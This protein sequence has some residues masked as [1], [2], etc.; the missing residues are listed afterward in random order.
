SA[1]RSRRRRP[2]SAGPGRGWQAGSWHGGRAEVTEIPD[3]WAALVLTTSDR[4]FAGQRPDR[5]GEFLSA[6]L[7]ELGFRVDRQVVP[8]DLDLIRHALVEGA[9][10]HRLVITT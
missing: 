5:S 3:R 6:R 9:A 10:T 8:D 1:P 4:S 7:V 2:R